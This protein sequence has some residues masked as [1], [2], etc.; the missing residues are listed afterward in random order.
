MIRTARPDDAEAIAPLIHHAIHEI[1]ETLTGASEEKLVLERLEAL[2]RLRGNR[3]SYENTLVAE[4][5]GEVAGIVI[6]YPGYEA[7]KLDANLSA[8]IVSCT[9]IAPEID[10]ET[11]GD[12]Y[13]ID[14]L[15]VAPAYG[16]KGIGTRLLEAASTRGE[17]LGCRS[18]TL[19]ADQSNAGA[20]RLYRRIGFERTKSIQISGSQF[21][22]MERRFDREEGQQHD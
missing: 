10:A 20:Q 21:D 22:Y 9:G 5:E 3:L 18:V 11:A 4:H 16:G 8:Y 12:V 2:V 17:K 19:N 7:E 15:S 6:A 13:Y 1:A 14:T